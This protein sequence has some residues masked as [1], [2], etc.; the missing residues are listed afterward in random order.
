MRFPIGFVLPF[1]SFQSVAKRSS[2]HISQGTLPYAPFWVSTRPFGTPLGPYA[3]KW[4]MTIL[5][6][7]AVPAGDAFNFVVDLEIYPTAFFTFLMALGLYLVRY[8]RRKLG[9][10][11]LPSKEGGFRAWEVAVLFTIAVNLYLL[12]M[13]WY[14]PT[15]GATGGDVSFWYA[16]YVVAGIGM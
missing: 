16:A 13:P 4:I 8:R 3:T 7:L 6:L 15:S 11:R 9:L 10:A 12:V 5:I 2:R 1:E 14:P